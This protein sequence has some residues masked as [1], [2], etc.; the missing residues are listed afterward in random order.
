MYKYYPRSIDFNYLKNTYPNIDWQSNQTEV[1]FIRQMTIKSCGHDLTGHFFKHPKY[2]ACIVAKYVDNKLVLIFEFI[3]NVKEGV[4]AI[5]G[6]CTATEHRRKGNTKDLI[7]AFDNLQ[8]TFKCDLYLFVDKENPLYNVLVKLYTD[9][10]FV[11]ITTA[12][13][14]TSFSKLIPKTQKVLEMTKLYSVKTKIPLHKNRL[15]DMIKFKKSQ[16]NSGGFKIF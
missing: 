5:T 11:P 9:M 6:I 13:K 3:L 15:L 2:I 14:K 12:S 1:K 8:K 7:I 10:G 16:V 4:G